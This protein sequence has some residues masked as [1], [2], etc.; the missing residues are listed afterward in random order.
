MSSGG[1]ESPVRYRA[2]F[3]RVL[4]TTGHLTSLTLAHYMPVMPPTNTETCAHKFLTLPLVGDAT[5]IEN[6][7]SRPFSASFFIHLVE[8][9]LLER[10]PKGWWAILNHWKLC[11]MTPIPG[12]LPILFK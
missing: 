11:L 8:S 4:F 5:V 9:V 3:Y 12:D 1:F 2:I 7:C 6:H 10:Y